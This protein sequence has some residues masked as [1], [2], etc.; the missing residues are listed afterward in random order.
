MEWQRCDAEL[1]ALGFA[2]IGDLARIGGDHRAFAL[3]EAGAGFVTTAEEAEITRL[4]PGCHHRDVLHLRQAVEGQLALVGGCRD[5][6]NGADVIN[7]HPH[8]PR[9]GIGA[10][11][12]GVLQLVEHALHF[13]PGFRRLFRIQLGLAQR[14]L[15]VEQY[16]RRIN[17]RQRDQTA[18]GI[19]DTRL[20]FGRN[21]SGT[22][23][24]AVLGHDLMQ[25]QEGLG[26]GQR[27]A[28]IVATQQ[29]QPSRLFALF[30]TRQLEVAALLLVEAVDHRLQPLFAH[31]PEVV[32]QLEVGRN[33]RCRLL[34]LGRLLGRLGRLD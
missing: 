14:I 34:C 17:H 7:M 4:G 33:G 28:C 23:G 5:A 13:E 30:Q 12:A 31:R 21:V 26:V 1:N 22:Q 29:V 32:G 2:E 10:L 3:V 25:R 16:R 27:L 9:R 24:L 15:V 6:G 19:A 11:V 20:Q 8:W 18:L